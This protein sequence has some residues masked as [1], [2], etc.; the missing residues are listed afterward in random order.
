MTI[1]NNFSPSLFQ[2]VSPKIKIHRKP[3]TTHFFIPYNLYCIIF[4]GK[5]KSRTWKEFDLT[6]NKINCSFYDI[7]QSQKLKS[8]PCSRV[9]FKEKKL[10]NIYFWG[11]FF[12]SS[13]F[14]SARCNW[15]SINSF[16]SFLKSS[17][18]NSRLSLILLFHLTHHFERFS[19]FIWTRVIVTIIREVYHHWCPDFIVKCV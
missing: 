17:S 19:R 4:T 7:Q 8:F 13:S 16:L 14:W 15:N 10:Y 3:Q 5:N 9:T 18:S 2:N 12:L 1:I 6:M 11:F